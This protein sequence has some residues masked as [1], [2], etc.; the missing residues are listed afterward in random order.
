MTLN[1]DTAYF[2]A[3]PLFQHMMQNGYGR[4]VFIGSRPALQPGDGKSKLAYSLSK[5]LLFTLSDMLNAEA[6]RQKT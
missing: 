2:L 4:L 1:F 5:S 3:R 6:K